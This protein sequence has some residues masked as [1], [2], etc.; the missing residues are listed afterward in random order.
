MLIDAHCH[1]DRTGLLDFQK[2]YQIQAIVNCD[3][4]AEWNVNQ[5]WL[6]RQE[7]DANSSLVS[8]GIHPWKVDQVK[9]ETM[10]PYLLQAP[11]AG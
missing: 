3:S 1:N 6:N 7:H 10:R 4:V 5:A 11:I 2:N 9:F 8:A